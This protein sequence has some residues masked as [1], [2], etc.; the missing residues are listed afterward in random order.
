MFPT[1]T[2]ITP[3]RRG[4]LDCFVSVWLFVLGAAANNFRVGFF[5][6][7]FLDFLDLSDS[8]IF[9]IVDLNNAAISLVLPGRE[10]KA[11]GCFL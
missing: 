10:R 6:L 8:G 1:C 5:T 7:V 3:K 9:K 11:V 2:G 4:E